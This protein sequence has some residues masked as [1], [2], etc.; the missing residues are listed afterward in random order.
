VQFH[1]L[2]QQMLP[3]QKLRVHIP[4]PHH[5]SAYPLSPRAHNENQRSPSSPRGSR[6]HEANPSIYSASPVVPLLCAFVP[7]CGKSSLRPP[8]HLPPKPALARRASLFH[9]T[10]RTFA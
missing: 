10:D 3:A 2:P 7:L 9:N 8:Q 4:H 5:Y 1:M 6:G